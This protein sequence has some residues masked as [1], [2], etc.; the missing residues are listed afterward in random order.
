MRLDVLF[1]VEVG[2]DLCCSKVASGVSGRLADVLVKHPRPNDRGRDED[3][4]PPSQRDYRTG[5]LPWVGGGK[6]WFWVRV[7]V[8]ELG[9]QPA[10]SRLNLGHVIRLFWL[11]AP[12]RPLP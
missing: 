4:S 1:C 9:S 11:P 3:C 7:H 2:S 6:A 8:P 12:Q 5:L 10:A